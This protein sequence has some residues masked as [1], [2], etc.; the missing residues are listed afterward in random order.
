M[1]LIAHLRGR[2][3]TVALATLAA[4]GL[5]GG[6]VAV[7]AT[8]GHTATTVNRLAVTTQNTATV[9]S[10]TTWTTVGGLRIYAR[11]GQFVTATFTA[12]SACIGPVGGW[13]SVRILIDGVEAEPVSGTDFAFDDAGG[14]SSWES[15][16]VA[17]VR[18]VTTTGFH[19]VVVQATE[20]GP[21]QERLDDWTLQALTATP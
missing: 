9:Y 13:C 17:R 5:A 8:T 11:A 4:V 16:S 2:V 3:A 15:H 18:T 6:G 14:A 19:T 10:G 1:K 21:V 20:I 7:A 12:E